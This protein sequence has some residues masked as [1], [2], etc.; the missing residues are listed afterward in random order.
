MAAHVFILLLLSLLTLPKLAD[1]FESLVGGLAPPELEEDVFVLPDVPPAPE[2]VPDPFEP[3]TRGTPPDPSP[4]PYPEEYY[5]PYYDAEPQPFPSRHHGW[6]RGRKATVEERVASYGCTLATEQSIAR[7]LRWLAEHQL[8]D[9]SWS[10]DHRLCPKC[11][12]RCGNPGTLKDQRFAATGLALLAFLGSGHTHKEGTYKKSV[13]N[14]LGWLVRNINV[15][16]GQMYRSAEG[17][18]AHG[19]ATVALCEA[20]GMT[21]DRSLLGPCKKAITFILDAQDSVGGGWGHEPRQHG[22][23]IVTGWQLLALKSARLAHIK[24][25]PQTILGV[26]NFLNS[27]ESESGAR[28]G[29]TTPKAEPTATAIGLLCRMH[30]GWKKDNG[31]LVRGVAA[32]DQA[33]FDSNEVFYNLFAAQVLRHGEGQEWE[34]FFAAMR[35]ELVRTQATDGHEKGSWFSRSGNISEEGGRHYLTCLNC[36][37][38]EVPYRYLPLSSAIVDDDEE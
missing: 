9:G 10:P 6:D 1:D 23:M 24:V 31:A 2:P 12:G 5:L 17:M 26:T 32:L 16:T 38:L 21:N 4:A 3:P 27:V 18:T 19:I 37:M 14:G 33:G 20:C 25:P 29:Q 11:G 36:M 34:R 15:Q 28:Y 7:A 30:L 22:D 35:G 13:Y 8:P